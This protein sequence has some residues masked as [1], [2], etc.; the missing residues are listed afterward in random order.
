MSGSA[1]TVRACGVGA[2][3]W[4]PPL[5]V[6]QVNLVVSSLAV[7]GTV[8]GEGRAEGLTGGETGL[9]IFSRGWVLAYSNPRQCPSS[10]LGVCWVAAAGEPFS[11]RDHILSLSLC[12][13]PGSRVVLGA[14]LFS[15]HTPGETVWGREDSQGH[16]NLDYA[17]LLR[18]DVMHGVGTKKR[19]QT[20]RDLLVPRCV[21]SAGL[22]SKYETVHRCC[23]LVLTFPRRDR[24]LAHPPPPR[25][26]HQRCASG[27]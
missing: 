17:G 26:P 11:A 9:C 3:L 13:Y 21:W 16:W 7:W 10:S 18:S 4:F 15:A 22:V 6:H 23:H 27:W 19:N 25:W 12:H 2:G 8:V 1:C 20:R 24:F 14:T 5:P